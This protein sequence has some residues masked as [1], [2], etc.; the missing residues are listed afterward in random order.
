MVEV[1]SVNTQ[2]IIFPFSTSNLCV[3]KN[4]YTLPRASEN[5]KYK[6][7]LFYAEHIDSVYPEVY[8]WLTN[9]A[10]EHIT[11]EQRWKI[12][13][14]CLSLYFRNDRVLSE[15]IAELESMF[16]RLRER[17]G[18]TEDSML[19]LSFL[20]RTYHFPK[21]DLDQTMEGAKK[22]FKEDFIVGHLAAWHEYIHFKNGAQIMVYSTPPEFPLITSDNPVFIERDLHDQRGVFDPVNIIMIPLDPEHY[23]WIAPNNVQSDRL[24]IY[25]GELNQWAALLLNLRSHQQASEWVIGKKGT[26]QLHRQHQQQYGEHSPE[27]LQSIDNLGKLAKG[28][29]ALVDDMEEKGMLHPSVIAQINLMKNDPVFRDDPGFQEMM[30]ELNHLG[31]SFV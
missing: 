19:V 10:V 18:R 14:C 22:D 2:K 26:V 16:E 12:L 8:A 5:E 13:S 29:Q 20:G 7:E 25:R 24:S 31:V 4:L 21:K 15:K 11:E 17:F 23:L 6:L 9:P 1:L 28:M 27:N 3:S 30:K